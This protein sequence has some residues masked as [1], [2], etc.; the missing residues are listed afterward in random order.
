MS[1]IKKCNFI[2][3]IYSEE[4]PARMHTRAQLKLSQLSKSGFDSFN[5]N[6][7]GNKID[8]FIEINTHRVIMYSDEIPE[9]IKIEELK[10]KGPKSDT[11]NIA[12]Q[13]FLNK[14]NINESDL[15]EE[16]G[17]FY[18]LR[19]EK[20]INIISLIGD[21]VI[22]F[23][24]HNDIFPVKMT[25]NNTT[26]EW[27]RPIRSIF[28]IFNDKNI[29]I[30]YAGVKSSLSTK[31]HKY[32]NDEKFLS[33]ENIQNYT[34]Y[35]KILEEN[36]IMMNNEKINKI[37]LSIQ[38]I[39][40]DLSIK[41]ERDIYQRAVENIYGLCDYPYPILCSFNESYLSIPQELIVE[42]MHNH[43]KYC[44][45]YDNNGKLMNKF[46][47]FVDKVPT[48]ESL[49]VIKSGNS[50]VITARLDDGKFHYTND[51]NTSIE[52]F[53]NRLKSINFHNKFGSLYDLTQKIID[54]FHKICSI[55][56]SFG[57]QDI[58]KS[59]PKSIEEMR[60]KSF[61]IERM[62]L[63]LVTNV[64]QEFSD[65]QGKMNGYYFTSDLSHEDKS[66]LINVSNAQYLYYKNPSQMISLLTNMEETD[67]L[68]LLS[69][70]LSYVSTLLSCGVEFSSSKD[71][72]GI[73]R[74]IK[75]IANIII[76]CDIS[77]NQIIDIIGAKNDIIEKIIFERVYDTSTALITTKSESALNLLKHTSK[78]FATSRIK[79]SRFCKVIAF[80]NS[81]DSHLDT[82]ISTMN[83]VINLMS[84]I[85]N[86][87]IIKDIKNLAEYSNHEVN[88]NGTKIKFSEMLKNITFDRV[89][90]SIKNVSDFI[91]SNYII[92]ENNNETVRNIS[93]LYHGIQN[94]IYEIL[95]NTNE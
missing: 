92:T 59:N 81:H 84:K 26:D 83:R 94:D 13:G 22:N 32:I 48:Q 86:F 60:S 72:F 38:D 42:V 91:D 58:E 78:L 11:N 1:Q 30:S 67:R 41:Y 64:V 37:E 75:N 21:M 17:Y 40:K 6:I 46:I 28:C 62:K 56:G 14:F 5:K 4:I 47:V 35:K 93:L 25:W 23:I 18:Y 76:F 12:K 65:L 8:P 34:E 9:C 68:I 2:L 52:S 19:K 85:D 29:D 20:S 39:C 79:L 43:Q 7:D 50:K 77:V 90:K 95:L 66:T 24:K 63:D 55:K 36:Y 70:H 88:M 61:L 33:L 45:L 27:I 51:L 31:N 3:E 80:I 16:D 69:Y 15:F 44:P 54:N 71:P 87:L 53:L 10:I 82:I 57:L 89:E 49:E 74:S 73:S